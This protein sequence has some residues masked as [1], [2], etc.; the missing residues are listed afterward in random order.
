MS[1]LFITIMHE[2]KAPFLLNKHNQD[3]EKGYNISP[4]VFVYGT[5]SLLMNLNL[6]DKAGTDCCVLGVCFIC[7]PPDSRLCYSHVSGFIVQ[8]QGHRP[9]THTLA[10]LWVRLNL[11]R[12]LTVAFKNIWREKWSRRRDVSNHVYLNLSCLFCKTRF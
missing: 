12:L 1:Q 11:P 8:L 3:Q 5:S 4:P 10:G 6:F 2:C 9:S 7:P